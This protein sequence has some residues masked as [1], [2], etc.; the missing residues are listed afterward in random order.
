[1]NTFIKVKGN[2]SL[3]RD[4]KSGAI[5]N[6]SKSEY[7]SYMN[8][9]NNMLERKSQLESNTEEINNIKQDISEIKQ[10]LLQLIKSKED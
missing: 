7:Q 8:L 3:V 1:M 4:T 9:K 6:T 10:M 2:P 5:I